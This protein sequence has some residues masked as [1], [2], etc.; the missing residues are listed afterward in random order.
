MLTAVLT[1]A[2]FLLALVIVLVTVDCFLRNADPLD[3]DPDGLRR[4]MTD[5][6]R[7]HHRDD[8][9]PQP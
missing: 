8:Q 6:D 7:T 2:G 1:T 4:A 3:A 9:E 5:P